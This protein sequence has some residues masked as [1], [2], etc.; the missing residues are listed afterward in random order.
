M[1]TLVSQ[2]GLN[3]LSVLTRI[4]LCVA[5]DFSKNIADELHFPSKTFQNALYDTFQSGNG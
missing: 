5:N 2:I 4:L 1:N 3:I